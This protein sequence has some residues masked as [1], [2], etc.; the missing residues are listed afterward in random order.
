MD[1]IQECMQMTSYGGEAKSLGMLAIKEAREG[2]FDNAEKS[3]LN[4][5]EA[6]KKSHQAHTKLLCNDAENEGMQVSLFMVHAA[7]HL[8]SAE[9][10]Y[11]LARELIYLH[12]SQRE[13]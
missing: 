4:A 2:N 6:L 10:I 12:K 13:K 1:I 8:T 7:D 9:I 5:E 11:E 3:L